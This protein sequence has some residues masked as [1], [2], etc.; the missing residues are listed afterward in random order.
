MASISH[1]LYFLPIFIAIDE[2]RVAEPNDHAGSHVMHRRPR[3][4]GYQ[5]AQYLHELVFGDD[6]G[7]DR[8]EASVRA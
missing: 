6:T 4:C 7:G 3:M 5:H 2:V 1:L 8:G